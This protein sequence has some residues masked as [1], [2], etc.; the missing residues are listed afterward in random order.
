MAEVRRVTAGDIE[1]LKATRLRALADAPDAFASTLEREQAF[2]DS[3]WLGRIANSAWFLAIDGSEP[4][5]LVCAYTESEHPELRH[6]VSMWVD[7]SW[8]GTDVASRLVE[9]LVAQAR[10]E[11]VESV[12]L[13]VADGNERARRF[14]ERIGFEGTGERA[15]LPSNPELGEEKMVLRLP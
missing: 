8:R 4:I 2:P 3:E 15:Q 6:L 11:A 10:A 12:V 9:A 13:W 5:G 7:P 14:Y 1:L